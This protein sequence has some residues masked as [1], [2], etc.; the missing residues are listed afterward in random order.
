MAEKAQQEEELGNAKGVFQ[1]ALTAIL[2]QCKDA[3]LQSD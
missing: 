3:S 2:T 1:N